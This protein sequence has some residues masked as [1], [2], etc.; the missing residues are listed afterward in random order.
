M[1]NMKRFAAIALAA[2]LAV[3]VWPA[4]E[5]VAHAGP[6][7]GGAVQVTY[8][9]V[10]DA[11]GSL[12]LA[13]QPA[14]TL[15]P[16]DSAQADGTIVVDP[17]IVYQ[18]FLGFGGTM[19]DADVWELNRLSPADKTKALND[20]FNPAYGNDYNLMRL[21]IGCSDACVSFNNRAAENG[22]W[23]YDD[24][25]AG[26]TDPNLTHFS[27]WRDEQ[28]GMIGTLQQILQ[29]NPDVKFFA[30][31]WSPPAWMK[32]NGS[33]I[34]GGS[35]KP[36]YYDELANYYVK[37]IDAYEAHG[38]PI[39]A[40]TLQNEPQIVRGY[41]TTVWTAQ[42]QAAFAVVLGQTFA[43]H[44]IKAK[45][46][47]HDDNSNHAFDFAEKVLKDPQA[48]AYIDGLGFHNY[49]DRKL[50]APTVLRAQYPEKTMHVTEI[51]Q[52]PG[53]LVE[54]FRNWISSYTYWLT[55]AEFVPE[56]YDENGN[57]VTGGGPGP[58]Y[59][60]DIRYQDNPNNPDFWWDTQV[61]WAG[62]AGT[63]TYKLNSRYYTFAQF[64]RFIQPG[65]VR[66]DSTE[67]L[68]GDSL[69]N[70]AFKNPD[71]TVVLIVVNRSLTKFNAT[72]VP[73]PSRT[74][75]IATPDGQFVDTIP[76]NVV[77]TYRWTSTTG[78]ALSRAGWNAYASATN[79][80]YTAT[81]AIDGSADTVW[82]SGANQASGQWFA[83]DLGAARTFDQISLH[84]GFLP[85]DGPA[86]YNVYTSDDGVG[87]G[88]PIHSG[89]GA[90]GMTNLALPTQTKRY[91]K[92]E[93]AGAANKGWTIGNVA[94][95]NGRSGLL[96]RA[97]WTASASSTES[98]GS[99]ANALDGN[100][101]TRWSNGTAP[102]PG[103][104][105]QVDLGAQRTFN[106]LEIDAGPS[107]GDYVRGYEIYVS[108][109]GVGWNGPIAAGNGLRQNVHVR[110][111]TQAAK[112]IRIAQTG[113]AAGNWWSIAELRVSNEVL[114]PLQ[115][116]GWSALSSNDPWN[117]AASALDGNAATRWTNGTA[118]TPGQWFQVDLKKVYA[119][120]GIRL[121]AG[122]STGDYPRGYEVTLSMDGTNWTTVAKGAIPAQ[123]NTIGFPVDHA[124]F[125]KVTHTGSS[126][127]SW[128]SI[129]EFDAFGAPAP[130]SF[131][132]RISQN[133][134][135]ATAQGTGFGS[136]PSAAVDG[137]LESS[138]T[139]GSG[140]N[141]TEHF[142]IDMGQTHSIS[143]VELNAAP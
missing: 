130:T 105:F 12:R 22:Y 69:T 36:E 114:A 86:A 72:N 83:L 44:G 51:T 123:D 52:G 77:A 122:S 42:E 132:T 91:V 107:F 73:T 90:Y 50:T 95:Y 93:L 94:L 127:N 120:T 3:P 97:G 24:M 46:W 8:S 103:Q 89:A 117:S 5:R 66:I 30:S 56:Q 7:S 80:A 67:G 19:L 23:T 138:W 62:T 29:I 79:G 129:H 2:T 65:A 81:Q 40:V 71:G 111:P 92:I 113:S 134:W 61:S 37:F 26:Q 41:P 15:V 53:K 109:D 47:A 35:V 143:M 58:G 98:G 131:G 13:A 102:A 104:W 118:P 68:F 115:R 54:Y 59:W 18:T 140:Q 20:L 43:A 14:K 25:P 99:A 119:I 110:F 34:N 55:F 82:N 75:K 31:M 96:S 33:L 1:R 112:F 87:W 126:N 139:T 60:Q 88:S 76:G 63:G 64:S 78:D 27:I 101:E 70:V 142:Q 48:N 124:R 106:K 74:I 6:G 116:T 11:S 125:I 21:T 57:W 39:Y 84:Q 17:S 128:W 108:N 49:D 28:S 137:T 32:T 121:D 10:N 141:G 136:A 133:G 45:I 38:I 100:L 4:P 9:S 16:V 135:S 85:N